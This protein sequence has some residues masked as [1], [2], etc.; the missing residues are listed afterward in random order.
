MHTA[1]TK[2]LITM[3]IY[4]GLFS[5]STTCPMMLRAPWRIPAAPNPAILLP[6]MNMPEDVAVAQ[7]IVPTVD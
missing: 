4:N 2:T 1:K 5:N 7:K 3:P 6:A